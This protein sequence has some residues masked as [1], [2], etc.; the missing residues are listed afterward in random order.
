MVLHMMGQGI[1]KL[2]VAEDFFVRQNIPRDDLVEIN[3]FVPCLG[4][5]FVFIQ[6][7][8]NDDPAE[9]TVTRHAFSF[10]PF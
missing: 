7:L 5:H 2:G 3:V 1:D 9:M 8:E 6:T 10:S 4:P